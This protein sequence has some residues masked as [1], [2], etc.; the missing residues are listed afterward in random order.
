MEVLLYETI[1]FIMGVI[2]GIYGL[3]I[4]WRLKR[5]GQNGKI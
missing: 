4:Y 1:C 5:R 3:L 2:V